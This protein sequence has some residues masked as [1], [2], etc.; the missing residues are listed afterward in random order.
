M[1]IAAEDM[2]FFSSLPSLF[3]VVMASVEK[4][5]IRGIRSF[6]PDC[7]QSI[8]F[9]SPLTMPVS[10]SRLSSKTPLVHLVDL[11]SHFVSRRF[12]ANLRSFDL[13]TRHQFALY[14]KAHRDLAVLVAHGRDFLVRPPPLVGSLD[15]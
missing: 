7:E 3:A 6:S 5:A 11:E 4:L 9:Y 14:P 8:E 1:P 12:L 15:K 13:Q 10:P 2:P